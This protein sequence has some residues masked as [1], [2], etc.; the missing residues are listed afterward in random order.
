MREVNKK[1]VGCIWDKG[2][3][4]PVHFLEKSGTITLKYYVALLGKLQQ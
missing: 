3:V 4:L 2:E 1:C